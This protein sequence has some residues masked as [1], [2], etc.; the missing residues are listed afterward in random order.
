MSFI[1]EQISSLVDNEILIVTDLYF[2]ITLAIIILLKPTNRFNNVP[3]RY[4][5]KCHKGG[6]DNFDRAILLIR[7]PFDAIWSEYERT[8]STRTV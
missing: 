2:N 7:N 4:K 1:L 3:Y 8:V 5:P 6:V